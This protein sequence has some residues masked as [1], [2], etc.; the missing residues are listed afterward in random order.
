ML[1]FWI[2]EKSPRFDSPSDHP[3]LPRPTGQCHMEAARFSLG[4]SPLEAFSLTLPG[5]LP[6]TLEV[7]HDWDKLGKSWYMPYM[8]HWA[9]MSMAMIFCY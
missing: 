4:G 9:M 1:L 3:E 6:L 2:R 5:G 8:E 7:R